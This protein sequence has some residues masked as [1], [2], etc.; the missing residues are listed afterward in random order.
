MRPLDAKSPGGR[1]A[2]REMG[3]K[4][5]IEKPARLLQRVYVVPT[6]R[7]RT[8]NLTLTKGALCLIELRGPMATALLSPAKGSF[9]IRLVERDVGIEP[10]L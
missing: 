8:C 2:P 6:A 5:R 7:I 4:A 9:Q 1:R 10:Y 3:D